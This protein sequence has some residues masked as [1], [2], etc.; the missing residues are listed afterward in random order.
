M[1]AH[2][3]AGVAIAFEGWERFAESSMVIGAV[4]L[5][6]GSL[7][8]VHGLLLRRLHRSRFSAHF[9]AAVF[10]IEAIVFA[11]IAAGFFEHG[12]KLLPWLYVALVIVYVTLATVRSLRSGSVIH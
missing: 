1:I 11:L 3:L 5:C 2:C 7:L 4:M 8:L 10:L 6:L 9:E 12:K